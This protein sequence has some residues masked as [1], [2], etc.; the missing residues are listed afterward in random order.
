MKKRVQLNKLK[1]DEQ[2]YAYLQD[3]EGNKYYEACW[4]DY[5][6]DKTKVRFKI[7]KLFWSLILFVLIM[8]GLPIYFLLIK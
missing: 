2:G 7:D 3:H 1:F 6:Q 5:V 8:M 4:S